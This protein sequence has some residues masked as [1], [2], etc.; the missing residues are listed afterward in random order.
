MEKAQRIYPII[1]RFGSEW[2]GS[3]T[4]V[5]LPGHVY[6]RCSMF[7]SIRMLFGSRPLCLTLLILTINFNMKSC[8]LCSIA[9]FPI[10][11]IHSVPPFFFTADCIERE[12]T[13]IPFERRR[14]VDKNPCHI[15]G[16]TARKFAHHRDFWSFHERSVCRDCFIYLTP[17]NLW[18]F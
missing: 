9:F 18:R 5:N 4:S 17:K 10:V 16:F 7:S 2:L 11:H 3:R 8:T 13:L 15:Y 6:H 12:V 1:W 14:R